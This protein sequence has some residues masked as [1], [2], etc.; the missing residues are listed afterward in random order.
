MLD[1]VSPHVGAGASVDQ[2]VL[3]A[4]RR[5]DVPSANMVREAHATYERLCPAA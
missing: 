2:V 1:A 3:A 4:L 5:A